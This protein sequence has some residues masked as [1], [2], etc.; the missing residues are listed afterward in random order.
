MDHTCI[1]HAVLPVYSYKFFV[2]LPPLFIREIMAMSQIKTIKPSARAAVGSVH[3]GLKLVP[4]NPSV[5]NH[6]IKQ[7]AMFGRNAGTC[8]DL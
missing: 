5:Y 1:H 3:K 8:K 6:N 7:A 4:R 2:M